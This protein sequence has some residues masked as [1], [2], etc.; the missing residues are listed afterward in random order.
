[1]GKINDENLSFLYRATHAQA[2]AHSFFA[3]LCVFRRRRKLCCTTVCVYKIAQRETS[4]ISPHDGIDLASI[5]DL[6]HHLFQD[7]KR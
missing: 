7:V 4:A 3:L 2:R 5:G 6:P 1:M